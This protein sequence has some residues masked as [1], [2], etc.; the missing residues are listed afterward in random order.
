MCAKI[1]LVAALLLLTYSCQE[2]ERAGEEPAG[3]TKMEI[4]VTSSAF[5]EGQMIPR[6]YTC[7]GANLSP[8]FSWTGVPEGAKS[9]ALICDDPDAPVGTWVH[10]VLYNLPADATALAEGIKPVEKLENGALQGSNDFRKLGY[11]GPCPP[12]G[13]HRYY[14]KFYALNAALELKPGAT[15]VDLMKATEGKILA[16]GQLMGKYT[17]K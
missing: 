3:G 5:Q 2:R 13:T 11:G 12:G 14:F 4:K 10:W 15:K 1:F 6:K 9:V 7:D 16:Q 8:P 17:R